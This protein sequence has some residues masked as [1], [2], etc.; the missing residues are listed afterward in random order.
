VTLATQSECRVSSASANQMFSMSS[1][2]KEKVINE[3]D[4]EYEVLTRT[5]IFESAV[6]KKEFTF[7]KFLLHLNVH[8]II[9][10][11]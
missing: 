9:H 6:I 4:E 2:E 1:E 7:T 11:S 3:L 10:Y 8:I 5:F